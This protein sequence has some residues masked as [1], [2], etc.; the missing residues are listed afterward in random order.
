M[1][2]KRHGRHVQCALYWGVI[3]EL[4]GCTKTFLFSNRCFQQPTQHTP[5]NFTIVSLSKHDSLNYFFFF[6]LKTV[7]YGMLLHIMTIF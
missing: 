7:P 2:P 6:L 5:L 4:N 3:S 1:D